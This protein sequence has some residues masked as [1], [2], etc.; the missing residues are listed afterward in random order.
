MRV[1]A[2]MKP[3]VTLTADTLNAYTELIDNAKTVVGEC[4]ARKFEAMVVLSGNATQGKPAETRRDAL[5]ARLAKFNATST[6]HSAV[7]PGLW[8]GVQSCTD[9]ADKQG[10]GQQKA[11]AA[12]SAAKK[13]AA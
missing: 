1:L 13:N 8:Q 3:F 12:S 5:L 9:G 7:S 4:E 6:P 11:G 2:K 10:A